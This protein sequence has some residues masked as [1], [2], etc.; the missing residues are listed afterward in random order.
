MNQEMTIRK[1]PVSDI[2]PAKYNPRKDLKPGDPRDGIKTA[3]GKDFWNPKTVQGMLT[4]VVY[5]GD[6]LYQKF[7]TV[8]TLQS[9]VIRNQGEEPQ[10]YIENHHEAIIKPEDWDRVQDIL[11]ERKRNKGFI[12]DDHRKYEKD[13]LK[14]EAFIEKLYCGE[15]GYMMGHRRSVERRTKTPF[16]THFWVCCRHDQTYRNERCSTRRIR[17]DYLEWNFIRFLKQ[18]HAD[19]NFPNDV[20]NWIKRLELT[21]EEKK[22]RAAL[23]ERMETQNQALYK[24]V[25]DGIHESGQNTQLVDK[26]TEELVELHSHLKHCSDRERRANHETKMF[27]EMMK[28]VKKYLEVEVEAF[29]ENLFQEFVSRTEVYEDGKVTYHLLFE[30]EQ[31]M[32]ETYADYVEIK[33]QNKK[34]KTKGKHEAILKGPEVQELLVFCEEPKALKEI[35]SF[36]N[37]RMVISDSH[38]FQVILRPLMK[39]GKLERF[40]APVE[41]GKGEVFHY[42]VSKHSGFAE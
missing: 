35:V 20:L 28:K 23:Q 13:V 2:E 22:E 26:L 36:M 33:R 42:Q 39:Q 10:Y 32:P 6:Y 30:L 4:N 9:K 17:Q 29:P 11:E 27:K 7:V 14:N 24:A 8:D 16:E 5:K 25:E 19:P 12:L 3:T 41:G 1:I 34:Q 40:K 31:K 38:I 21:D 15:C 18:I 37:E